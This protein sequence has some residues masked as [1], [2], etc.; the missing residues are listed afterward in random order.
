MRLVITALLRTPE[1]PKPNEAELRRT[2]ARVGEKDRASIHHQN[3]VLEEKDTVP[4]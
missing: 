4:Q 3:T 2:E 1:L